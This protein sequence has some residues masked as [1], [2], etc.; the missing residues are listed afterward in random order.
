MAPEN[1]SDARKPPYAIPW[2]TFYNFVER[3][4]QEGLPNRIDK[5][6][7]PKLSY[8]IQ[9]Y[10]MSALR[11]FEL[12]DDN[13]NV[14][15]LL[16]TLVNLSTRKETMAHLLRKHYP[17]VVSLGET[18][19]TLGELNEAFSQMGMGGE[20]R[21][22]GITFYLNAA[23]YAGVRTSPLWKGPKS[24]AAGTSPRAPRKARPART[25]KGKSSNEEEAWTPA[26]SGGAASSS[27]PQFTVAL[28]SGGSV[29]LAYDLNLFQTSDADRAF[30]LR[31]V[32]EMRKYQTKASTSPKA[33]SKKTE[34]EA[35]SEEEAVAL[36]TEGVIYEE[37]M[38]PGA[39]GTV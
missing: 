31:L 8:Q 30:V 19:A 9:S 37:G 10:L 22:K 24:P 12:I 39:S 25:R 38:S 6:L 34:S 36:P 18:N 11:T 1:D 7:M 26:N 21:R 32:D 3:L 23:D 5:T 29:T 28:E 13:G 14:Q 27:V 20:A 2:I 15:D 17:K 4:G 16:K 33:K 35:I